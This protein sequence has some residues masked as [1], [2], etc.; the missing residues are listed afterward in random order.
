MPSRKLFAI[1]NTAQVATVLKV[2]PGESIILYPGST[3][4][5][6]IDKGKSLTARS[7]HFLCQVTH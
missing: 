4:N 5:T 1:S 6:F 7:E 2:S 3:T